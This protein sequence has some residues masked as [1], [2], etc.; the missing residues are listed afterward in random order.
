[1]CVTVSLATPRDTE[2][3]R[4]TWTGLEI[5]APATLRRFFLTLAIS[6]AIYICLGLALYHKLLSPLA[7]G[8]IA[9]G[10]TLFVFMI[11]AKNRSQRNGK[12]FLPNLITDDLFHAGALAA[13]AV[14]M[15]GYFA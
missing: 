4:F 14:F 5:F 12:S 9:A 7:T 6:I 1:M 3:E 13:A 2:K 10:W 15:L 11:A 8:A